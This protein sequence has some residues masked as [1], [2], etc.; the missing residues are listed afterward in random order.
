MQWRTW[1]RLSSNVNFSDFPFLSH[2]P[3]Q[4][5]L[6][7]VYSDLP[8]NF[9][10][11][12]SVHTWQLHMRRQFFNYLKMREEDRAHW[13]FLLCSDIDECATIPG[14]CANGQC[15]NTETGYF[16]T[17]FPGFDLSADRKSCICKCFHSRASTESFT[18]LNASK[19][20]SKKT[21]PKSKSELSKNGLLI[22]NLFIYNDIR[23]DDLKWHWRSYQL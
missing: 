21:A 23:F 10:P 4:F 7:V 8:T 14:I 3:F 6:S 15:H 5:E 18:R 22:I 20:W 17:C 19:L 13:L 11:A 16:C 2:E 1:G 12:Y 9:G